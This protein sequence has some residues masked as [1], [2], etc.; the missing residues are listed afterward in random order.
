[1]NANIKIA[2]WVLVV[3]V[4]SFTGLAGCGY[5][6]RSM[7][8]EKY[9]TIHVG[10]FINKIDVT[11]D[12]AENKYRIYRPMLESSLT[13]AVIDRYLFEGTLKPVA[14]E[15]ADLILK[16]ELVEFERVPLKYTSDDEIQEY[17]INL[18]VNI[19]VREA[20]TDKL[21]WEEKHFAGDTTYY[22]SGP[23]AK[24]EDEAVNLAITDLSRRIVERTVEYWQ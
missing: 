23:L 7:I 16:A 1:M 19:S 13:Q 17:R 14:A 5:T 6:T 12:F 20:K 3:F 18:A 8:S 21:I 4:L 24:S 2:R 11:S 10:Q 15:N 22:T 9:K